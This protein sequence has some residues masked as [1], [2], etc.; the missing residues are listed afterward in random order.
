MSQSILSAPHFHNEAAAYRFVEARV[1][2]KGPVCP[3]CGGVER[4]RPMTGKTT[5]I[6]KGGTAYVASNEEHGWRAAADGPA[7]YFVLAIGRDA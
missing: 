7:K 5:R 2:P 6:G 1:W 4:N 3:H